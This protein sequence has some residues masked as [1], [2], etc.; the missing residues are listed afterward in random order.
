[1]ALIVC[2][3]CKKEVSDQAKV[4]PNCGYTITNPVETPMRKSELSLV[5]KHTGA[6]IGYITAGIFAII[7]GAFTLTIIIGIF[8]II[9][10]V[11]LISLGARKLSGLQ[12]GKCPYCGN[13]VSVLAKAT[14]YKC[15]HCKKVSSKAGNELRAIE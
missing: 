10:G 14:T 5:E 9:G 15:S 2:P 1:M 12:N 13:S 7:G 4:C 8:A 6:G 3:E 11:G